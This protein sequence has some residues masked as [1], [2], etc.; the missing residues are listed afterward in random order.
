MV[1]DADLAPARRQLL[2]WGATLLTL[3]AALFPLMSDRFLVYEETISYLVVFELLALA[4]Y[5]FA[6]PQLDALRVAPI[7]IAAGVGLLIRPTGLV[8]LGAW[9]MIVALESRRWRSIAAFTVAAAP[10]VALWLWTNRVRSGS[11]FGLGLVNALPYYEQHVLAQRFGSPCVDTPW[12]FLQV[13]GRLF[14]GF[15]FRASDPTS[16]WMQ[17][18]HMDFERRPG[19]GWIYPDEGFFGLPVFALLVALAVL[20][21]RDRGFRRLS[22]LVPLFAFAAL[23]FSYARSGVGAAWRYAGDFW[24]LVILATVQA[25]GALGRQGG[26]LLAPPTGFAILAS[27]IFTFAR[28]VLPAV[29]GLEIIHVADAS[30]MWNDFARSRWSSDPPMPSRISC[31]DRLEGP[32]ENGL[33]WTPFCEVAQVT[34]VYVGVPDGSGDDRELR[35]DAPGATAAMLRVFVNGRIYEARRS[36][37]L[38]SARVHVRRQDLFSPV[39]MVTIEWTRD[40]VQPWSVALR[41][42]ELT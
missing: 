20:A 34:N 3:S 30:D 29:G 38:Y 19:D 1:G 35:F 13:V 6:Q 33:G 18:C 41:S 40:L 8:L 10:F 4:A 26:R 7:A 21:F 25:V 12:H 9:W 22:R 2:S 17:Q 15:F 5:V 23:F 27:A 42:V 31:G 37:D 36:G 14:E 16:K 39:V 11:P 28:H 32:Y 24:P